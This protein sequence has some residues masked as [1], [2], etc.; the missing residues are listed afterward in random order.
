MPIKRELAQEDTRRVYV[1]G[2]GV[3]KEVG[4]PLIKNFWHELLQCIPASRRHRL[5]RFRDAQ[6][7]PQ[8]IEDVLTS[9]DT[10]IFNGT[11]I[12]PYGIP[13][14]R[15]IR[16]D[17]VNS[18]SDTFTAVQHKFLHDH[19]SYERYQDAYYYWAR[20]F[21]ALDRV[22]AKFPKRSPHQ[23]WQ[24]DR[25]RLKLR[26]GRSLSELGGDYEAI[27][28]LAFGDHHVEDRRVMNN[29]LHLLAAA[30][31]AGPA[32]FLAWISRLWPL[33]LYQGTF[34]DCHPALRVGPRAFT[35]EV[36]LECIKQFLSILREPA[37]RGIRSVD[38]WGKRE[39]IGLM[40]KWYR[41]GEIDGSLLVEC[42]SAIQKDVFPTLVSNPQW[43][44]D[45][46]AWLLTAGRINPYVLLAALWKPTGTVISLNYDL[47]PEMALNMLHCGLLFP[48]IDYGIRDLI[49]LTPWG[50]H[51][52]PFYPYDV[53][54]GP[55]PFLLLK[56]HGSINWLQCAS[57]RAMYCTFAS[58]ANTPACRYILQDLNKF[59]WEQYQ[60][61]PCCHLFKLKRVGI[62]I[63]PPVRQKNME[64]APGPLTSVWREARKKIAIAD[65][66]VFVGYAF[67]PLDQDMRDLIASAIKY[68][69]SGKAD[70]AD[71]QAFL[72]ERRSVADSSNGKTHL[73]LED[74]PAALKGRKSLS[75]R[76]LRIRVVNPSKNDQERYRQFFSRMKG[77][78]LEEF[79]TRGASDYLRNEFVSSFS[80]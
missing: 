37:A 5:A 42:T 53:L 31:A 59:F 46:V 22:K 38:G 58:P 8:N 7:R 48:G 12:G 50:E 75:Q 56:P 78:Y 63:V 4:A 18:I 23:Q 73:E 39:L 55:K 26:S 67:R 35:N 65:E 61:H 54:L 49:A 77:V 44:R 10:S 62:P 68:R 20:D 80:S 21:K 14:L 29:R 27:L 43:I 30:L 71:S 11:P 2:A 34:G 6:P 72:A 25:E 45:Q 69:G 70:Q 36:K 57:C 51:G 15:A 66:V 28:G 9:I 24:V 76:P 19:Y 3:S 60:D 13:A 40:N 32:R 47:F 41:K 33:I 16:S 1:I 17:I 79:A 74:V 52:Q 64:L